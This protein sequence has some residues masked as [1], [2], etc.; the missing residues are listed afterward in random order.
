M[1]RESGENPEQ[2]RCC[3]LFV[4]SVHSLATALLKQVG[5]RTVGSESEDLQNRVKC[6]MR[7]EEKGIGVFG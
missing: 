4:S 2:S 5:R 1:K 6:R 3:E 7:L